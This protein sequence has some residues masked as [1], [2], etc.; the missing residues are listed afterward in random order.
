MQA[1]ACRFGSNN[2][3][4]MAEEII[5]RR[6]E[7]EV[8]GAVKNLEL[9]EKASDDVK[10]A[11]AGLEKQMDA[12]PGP[13]GKVQQGV[14]GL[15]KAFKAL[16][17]NPIVL[18]LAAIVAGLVALAKAFSK[19]QEGAD[20][21]ANVMEGIKAV[22]DVVVER[23]AKL[24]KALGKIFTGKFKEG[25]D[26]VKESVSGMREEMQ[27]AVQDAIELAEAQ[28][29]LYAA[30]TE[31]IVQNAERRKQMADLILLSRDLTLSA[32]DRLKAV[33][34]A[35]EI[36]KEILQ[37][38]LELQRERL[39]QAEQEMANTPELQ[40]S[41]EQERA[42]AEERV[43]LIQL[44]TDAT[45]KLREI[46]NR[47]ITLKNEIRAR[48]NAAAAER[49]AQMDAEAEAEE[50]DLERKRQLALDE[51]E[52][53]KLLMEEMAAFEIDMNEQL[54]AETKRINDE[55]TQSLIDSAEKRFSTEEKLVQDQIAQEQLLQSVKE[56][57]YANS[58]NALIGFLG[59]GSKL[60]KGIQI[61][62]ATRSAIMGAI[63]A[64]TST[65][66]LGAPIGTILAPIAAAAALAAGMAQVKKI[67]STKS[68]ID[69]SSGTVPSVSLPQRQ[70]P[71]GGDL[72]QADVG[73]PG[74]VN[75]I[76]DRTTRT[77]QKAYV[78]E[79]EVTA[80]QEIA[81]QREADV[82]L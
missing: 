77:A 76:Q 80:K 44:E 24:F 73:I 4:K 6:I 56:S 71:G 57:I 29:R 46:V 58:L 34:A 39:R 14:K 9:V 17:A 68:P 62:D 50:A 1:V 38:N 51:A 49:Q 18:I 69:K 35:G 32:E 48:D 23:A 28:R 10:E 42:I 82:T 45:N 70:L 81:E 26:E 60:A 65:L 22:I 72:A 63:N 2:Y 13:L 8:D 27:G 16:L 5:V 3:E 30:Q 40:R 37:D 75:I 43:K 21:F 36:E 67:A 74:D 20:K 7:I 59:E 52:I 31:V 15:S 12:I 61:A 54:A 79:S 11:G 66:Q 64:F 47:E 25:F 19:T 53:D 33:T 41:R 55:T 78:V